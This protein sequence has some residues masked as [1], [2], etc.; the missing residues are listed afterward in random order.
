MNVTTNTVNEE[1][2]IVLHQD[3]FTEPAGAKIFTI[4]VEDGVPQRGLF[5]REGGADGRRLIP[6]LN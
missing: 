4:D 5:P 6:L 2:N 3:E 1:I